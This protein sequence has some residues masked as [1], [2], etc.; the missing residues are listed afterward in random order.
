MSRHLCSRSSPLGVVVQGQDTSARLCLINVCRCGHPVV[1]RLLSCFTCLDACNSCPQP[2]VRGAGQSPALSIHSFC[3]LHGAAGVRLSTPSKCLLG[4]LW[5]DCC[6]VRPAQIL[7]GKEV[8]RPREV[9]RISWEATVGRD[10]LLWAYD[11]VNVR[12]S[13]K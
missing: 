5:I 9:G 8:R 12:S 2:C 7:R 13:H 6:R 4:K 11:A 1:R 10:F 3:W